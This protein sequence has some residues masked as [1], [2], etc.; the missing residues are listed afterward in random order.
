VA[1]SGEQIESALSRLQV[2]ADDGRQTLHAA[3]DRIRFRSSLV[4]SGPARV[5]PLYGTYAGEP[6]AGLMAHLY[7][8]VPSRVALDIGANVGDVSHQLLA[9]GYEVFAFEPHAEVF[10]QLTG[11][12]HGH[13]AFHGFPL[14]LGSANETRPLHLAA[15]RSGCNRYRD[16]TLYSSLL[17]H[18]MPDDLVFTST[19]PV[20]VRTLASLHA[21]GHLPPNVG[22]VKIDTE[23]FDLEV[24]RGMDSH[25]YP[26]V[27]AE[28]WDQ[29]TPFGE[30]GAMNRLDDLVQE[31][32]SRDYHWYIV[33]YRVWGKSGTSFYCNHAHSV[34]GAFGNVYFF[35][36]QAIFGEA[37]KW[38]A[39]VL[40]VTYLG[41]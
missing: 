5:L 39:A 26:V 34:P 27:V 11:R 29:A 4:K 22:V 8:H 13:P 23:G 37:L 9:A 12:F 20:T 15:D 1:Q 2:L 41:G 33:F 31:M 6:E 17:H 21:A 7:A 32:R 28:Y 38:C 18:A 35:R 30:S 3:L 16:S 24:I 14:A 36:D 40:P 19:I 25:R 10:R